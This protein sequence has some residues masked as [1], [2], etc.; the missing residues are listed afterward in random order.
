LD[1]PTNFLDSSGQDIFKNNFYD[2]TTL[3]IAHRLQTILSADKIIV[4]SKG[5]I[6][7]IG[8][9]GE[10]MTSSDFYQNFV[11]FEAGGG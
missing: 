9:H 8:T 11:R 3:I 4:M 7:T 2:G 1:E 10:L 6:E 5:K